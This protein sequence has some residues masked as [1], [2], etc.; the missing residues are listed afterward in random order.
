MLVV[1]T[2][3]YVLT[4]HR[5]QDGSK[6]IDRCGDRGSSILDALPTRSATQWRE[7]IARVL[8][9]GKMVQSE[10][11]F[12]QD[13]VHFFYETRMVPYTRDSVLVMLR[14]VSEKRRADAKVRRL[15]FFDT[16]TGLPN[17]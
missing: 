1:D 15:A 6:L 13:G 7:H 5:G 10:D 2:G 9:T 11:H 12:E 3:G 4:R 14:D 16:L 17:R 8:A